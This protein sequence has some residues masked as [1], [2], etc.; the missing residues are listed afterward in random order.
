M[1]RISRWCT[2]E[3]LYHGQ[4]I[5]KRSH[6]SHFAPPTLFNHRPKIVESIYILYIQ[7]L[8][9]LGF[10]YFL[11]AFV[12]IRSRV[13]LLGCCAR[14]RDM[15][16]SFV[17]LYSPPPCLMCWS[18]CLVLWFFLFF[19]MTAERNLTVTIPNVY[20]DDHRHR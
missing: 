14:A 16:C 8:I 3:H 7:H 4:R 1:H 12:L 11:V 19:L 17:V 13:W 9:Y 15:Q 2:F 10:P 18:S 6:L 5:G 20:G